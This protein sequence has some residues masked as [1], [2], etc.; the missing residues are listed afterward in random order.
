MF[1]KRKFDLHLPLYCLSIVLKINIQSQVLSMK[2]NLCSL[3]NFNI[4]FENL[5][6][7]KMFSNKYIPVKIISMLIFVWLKVWCANIIKAEYTR[8]T[9]TVR[10]NFWE[11]TFICSLKFKMPL[12]TN[13]KAALMLCSIA[14]NATLWNKMVSR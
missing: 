7:K 8:S 12:K 11:L 13:L 3:D 2:F 4:N 6:S 14:I 1:T 10:V 9:N 5:R